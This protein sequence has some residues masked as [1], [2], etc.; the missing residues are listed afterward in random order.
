MLPTAKEEH[1]FHDYVPKDMKITNPDDSRRINRQLCGDL[2]LEECAELMYNLIC[3]ADDAEA[4]V[5]H[6]GPARCGLKKRL[7]LEKDR[8]GAGQNYNVVEVDI[9]MNTLSKIIYRCLNVANT[10][11]SE[12]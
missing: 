1:V 5:I 11:S 9:D 8:P 10:F 12:I 2:P 4:V 7:G 6:G 3:E